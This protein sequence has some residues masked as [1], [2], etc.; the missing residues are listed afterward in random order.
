MAIA[1]QL[2]DEALWA[3]AVEAYGW[4]KIVGGEL[5]EGFE[6]EAAPSRRRIGAAGRYSPG[7]RR[8]SVAR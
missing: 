5:A 4:H 1:E 7:W 2:G 8:T 3:G 6:A